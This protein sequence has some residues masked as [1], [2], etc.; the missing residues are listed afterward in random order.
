M[1]FKQKY[2][3]WL[4]EVNQTLDNLLVEK[5]C[6]ERNLYRA[7]KYSLSAGGKRLRPILSIAVCELFGAD[8]KIALPYACAIEMIHTYSLIHD[9]LPAMDNDDYRRG[10]PTN[11]KVFG[12][13][14]AILAGDALLNFAFEIMHQDILNS[15]DYLDRRIKAMVIISNASGAS[16]M[17]GGQAVDM[18]SSGKTVTPDL[19]KYMYSKKTGALIKAPIMAAAVL[20][21]AKPDELGLLSEY[22]EKI[23][24]AFQIK[25]DILDLKGSLDVMGKMSGSDAANN[26]QTFVT[27]YG[28]EKAEDILQQTAE[29]ALSCIRKLKYKT[30]FLEE[31]V[32]Y[33][34]TRGN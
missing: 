2:E 33:I 30:D 8:Y 19:L 14:M 26:K 34:V 28:I 27:V 3:Q 16:G 29:E 31:L 24:L 7:M 17:V 10:K 12:E 32:N 20:C 23:G 11:H 4:S 5:D 22:A 25:D 13:A 15:D 1:N 21:G 6:P 18:E 9:D